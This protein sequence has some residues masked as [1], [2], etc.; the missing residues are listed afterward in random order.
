MGLDRSKPGIAGRVNG[1]AATSRDRPV[2][3]QRVT[4]LEE[5]T[6]SVVLLNRFGGASRAE[7]YREEM[8]SDV[9]WS[10][11]SWPVR[12]RDQSASV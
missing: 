10:G 2:V 3:G 4:P 1:C 11:N 12:C 9:T 8:G 5:V 6:A 7:P